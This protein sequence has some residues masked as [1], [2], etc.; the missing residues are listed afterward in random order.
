MADFMSLH[1]ASELTKS[2]KN[3]SVCKIKSFSDTEN[4]ILF[5]VL[6]VK[7]N[8]CFDLSYLDDFKKILN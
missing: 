3:Y 1:F 6:L 7:Y 8:E 5:F 2:E 4:S